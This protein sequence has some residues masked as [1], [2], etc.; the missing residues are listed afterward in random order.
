MTR[1]LFLCVCAA[2]CVIHISAA[3]TQQHT[4]DTRA[5]AFQLPKVFDGD[6][7][8]SFGIQTG[9]TQECVFRP[10]GSALSRLDWQEEPSWFNRLDASCTVFG[11]HIGVSGIYSACQIQNGVMED[12]DWLYPPDVSALTHY[13]KH[14]LH[15]D[16][17][18][19]LE[20]QLGYTLDFRAIKLTV[21]GGVRFTQQK[22]TAQ[23]GFVQYGEES[24][25]NPWVTLPLTGNEARIPLSGTVVTYEQFVLLP[26]AGVNIEVTLYNTARVAAFVHW[27]PYV[28]ANTLDIHMDTAVSYY[29][30][31]RGGMGVAAGLSLGYVFKPNVLNVSSV[32]LG[33][34]YEYYKSTRGASFINDVYTDT[35]YPGIMSSQCSFSLKVCFL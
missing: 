30:E 20:G 1:K 2:V 7:A 22:W 12:Y 27:Y 28:W 26:F 6:I 13:S 29:D 23:D 14:T 17:R 33:I 19:M 16:K 8:C 3:Q 32:S 15:L 11:V 21:L 4:A 31:I 18:F 25:E 9:I 34:Q 35:S 10:D 5:L 24:T